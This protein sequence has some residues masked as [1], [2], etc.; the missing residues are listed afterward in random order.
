MFYNIKAKILPYTTEVAIEASAVSLE[1]SVTIPSSFNI[2]HCLSTE[3][4]PN[5]HFN[6]SQYSLGLP[7]DLSL[8]L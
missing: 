1:I 4:R 3:D 8:F 5:K 2:V 6:T 7:D